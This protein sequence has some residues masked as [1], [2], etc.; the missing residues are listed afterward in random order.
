MHTDASCLTVSCITS[1]NLWL[2]FLAEAWRKSECKWVQTAG[3]FLV[4]RSDGGPGGLTHQP[5]VLP[6]PFRQKPTGEKVGRLLQQR[7]QMVQKVKS[8]A[9]SVSTVLLVTW[10]MLLIPS[11]PS[12]VQRVW[13][14]PPSNWH[15]M[16]MWEEVLSVNLAHARVFWTFRHNGYCHLLHILYFTSCCTFIHINIQNVHINNTTL[17]IKSKQISPWIFSEYT[18]I[19]ITSEEHNP[20][21]PNY[22][23]YN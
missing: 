21:L 19:L 11:W 4:A 6:P 22:N 10:V 15:H 12:G 23:I 3:A 17:Q 2:F 7:D 1:G 8:T 14:A 16:W 5:L 20:G 13:A 9:H 18:F